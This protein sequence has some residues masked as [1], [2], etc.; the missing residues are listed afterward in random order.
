MKK[1]R[2]SF[3]V[4][5]SIVFLLSSCDISTL[6]ESFKG[7]AYEDL[8][9]MNLVG[10]QAQEAV[11]TVVEASAPDSAPSS[12]AVDPSTNNVKVDQIQSVEE[13]KGVAPPA[14]IPSDDAEDPDDIVDGQ[15]AVVDDTVPTLPKQSE[16]EKAQLKATVG[17]ALS[18]EGE[19]DFV[20]S[21][22]DP[23]ED[24]Q[25]FAAHNT[26]VLVAGVLEDVNGV[27]GASSLSDDVK[28]AVNDF[29]ENLVIELPASPTQADILNAQL[30]ANLAN[31][32]I[33]ALNV[34]AGD[35]DIGEFNVD[36]D[37]EDVKQAIKQVVSDAAFMVK[38]AKAQGATSAL[39]NSINVN[40]IFSMFNN[41]DSSSSRLLPPSED[42]PSDTVHTLP[43]DSID[44]LNNFKS[45]INLVLQDILGV[46]IDSEVP[47]MDYDKFLNAI[48]AYK[49]QNKAFNSF[50]SAA[51]I[52]NYDYDDVSADDRSEFCGITGVLNYTLA[53]VLINIDPIL[54][55][56]E[57][58]LSGTD[59]D[60]VEALVNL[61]L[62]ANSDLINP[63][64]GYED[65]ME[66]TLPGE[67]EAVYDNFSDM[68]LIMEDLGL[69][70]IA[71]KYLVNAK[72]LATLGSPVGSDNL[73]LDMLNEVT[74]PEE[75]AK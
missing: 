61:I 53:T 24:E 45:T 50:I 36:T 55:E 70:E 59:Y 23:A 67:L 43:A 34:L 31:S 37:D 38:V 58:D 56:F 65:T 16:E 26:S 46:D 22:Q 52:G 75:P 44:Y 41:D 29:T 18:G 3:I 42:P 54:L 12:Q 7:N 66:V 47:T 57:E 73:L 68:N 6:L 48:E 20:E 8:F 10:E 9:D 4:I 72:L 13:P 71:E 5:I 2:I 64:E 63:E 60:T 49:N 32:M 28:E 19:D 15:I 21:L 69:R 33:N 51:K 25:V 62:S 17:Q 1:K 40:S 35:G 74:L 30:A 14:D 39:I 27:V 11:N